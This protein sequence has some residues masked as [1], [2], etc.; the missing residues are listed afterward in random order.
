[1]EK[2]GHGL[3]RRQKEQVQPVGTTEVGSWP[4]KWGTWR[5]VKVFDIDAEPALVQSTEID[6]I[7]ALALCACDPSNKGPLLDLMSCCLRILS[8]F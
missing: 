8:D 7:P 1:M 4:R 3:T 6:P 5:V 2:L